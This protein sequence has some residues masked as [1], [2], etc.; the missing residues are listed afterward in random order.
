[1]SGLSLH[2]ET[3]AHALRV[4]AI[5]FT[6]AGGLVVASSTDPLAA[7]RAAA[8]WPDDHRQDRLWQDRLVEAALARTR[9]GVIYDPA[10]RAIA[11]PM[12]D[13]DDTKGVCTDVIIRAY[14]ALGVDLQQRVHEDM[15]AHFAAYPSAWGMSRPDPNI[16]HRRVLNLEAFFTRS[17]AAL[18]ITDDAG[19]YRP[20]DLVTWRLDGRLPHI[21]IVTDRR[22]VDGRRPLIVHNVGA[23][24]VLEDVLFAYPLAGHYRYAP[25][26]P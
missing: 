18:D 15:T 2:S 25:P 4:F 3:F 14:R 5:L 24:T 10:Y 6:A 13:V 7:D 26:A 17:G 23:G 21:G 11:Y 22:A 12:G 8:A 20:G 9:A 16:D 1:M 19:D